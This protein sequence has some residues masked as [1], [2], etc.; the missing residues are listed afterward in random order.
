M[1]WEYDD[2][3]DYETNESFGDLQIYNLE[4]GWFQDP[5]R[6]NTEFLFSPDGVTTSAAGSS[7]FT[8]ASNLPQLF[9]S[10]GWTYDSLWRPDQTGDNITLTL[11]QNTSVFTGLPNHPYTS[12]EA[13]TQTLDREFEGA[14]WEGTW[15][16]DQ[17]TLDIQSSSTNLRSFYYVGESGND[18]LTIR[19]DFSVLDGN[20]E[21]ADNSPS[22]VGQEFS[23]GSG[24]DTLIIDANYAD[25]F[26]VNFSE[27]ERDYAAYDLGKIETRFE[28]NGPGSSYF[29]AI[30]VE[31][32]V[33]SDKTFTAYDGTY[34][35]P[36][37][38]PTAKYFN[39]GLVIQE[40]DVQSG[41][42]FGSIY[43]EL[44]K[45][46]DYEPSGDYPGYV[47]TADDFQALEVDYDFG[48]GSYFSLQDGG[49]KVDESGNITIDTNAPIYQELYQGDREEIRVV[50]NVTDDYYRTDEG[51]VT[52][53]VLGAGPQAKDF[54]SGLVI[55]EDIIQSGLNFGTIYSELV[56]T[57]AYEASDDNPGYIFTARDFEA[58]E[59]ILGSDD[60]VSLHEGG[61]TVDENGNITIDTN[62]S[63][64]QKLNDGDQEQAAVLFKVTDNNN[65]SDIGSVYFDVT[66]KDDPTGPASLGLSYELYNSDG[67]ALTQLSVL[68]DDVKDTAKFV[69]NI[70]AESLESDFELESTDLTVRFNPNL[71]NSIEASDITIGGSLPVANAVQIDNTLGTIRIAA[72]SLSELGEG[73]SITDPSSLA[74]ISLDFD[75]E[76][77]KTL[78]KNDD[79]SLK[80]NPLAFGITANSEE[81]IFSTNFD[82]GSGFENR[83]I[84]TLENLGGS[85]SVEGKDVTLYEAKIN[86]AQ[87]G[88]GLVLGT[89]RVI[90]SDASTTNLIRS[91]DTL[92]TSAEWLNIGNIK[93]H[94]LS[95]EGLHN[96][97]A[98]LINAEFS[99]S[100]I[101]S[102][103]FI[104]GV[105]VKEAR[106]STTLTTDIK[107][108][109]AAGN[110]VDLADGIVSVKA[111]AEGSEIFTNQ[112]KGSSNL[113]T[114]QGDLNYD[115][116]VS[117]KDLAY[118]NAGA[119]RQQ[120]VTI[121]NAGDEAV[122]LEGDGI[123]DAS[124]ARDVDADFNG[125]I[126][127][128]D[129]SVLDADWGK[130][131]HTGDHQFQGSADISW[132]QLDSQGESSTWDNTSFKNQNAIE[133]DSGYVGSLEAPG[134][135]GVIGSDGNQDGPNSLD[136]E[137]YQNDSGM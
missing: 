18:T 137:F 19:G 126:D 70:K 68:G 106:E 85:I 8:F 134:T 44:V 28:I 50:F 39:S 98:S 5:F 105:F 24:Y 27:Q 47:F 97:N 77:I 114:F 82:D 133:A 3:Y 43:S 64:Y 118:L 35:G 17:F 62:A 132:N 78:A 104:D 66:G 96:Q 90:G 84:S 15:Y 74:S 76:Q 37:S 125:R 124:V 75:E 119:A 80:I 103:S 32:V 67:N 33:F 1:A 79:G 115:G 127:L 91:G 83:Q 120:Q 4:T 57:K 53:E 117:M 72:A 123:V 81:T 40:G 13:L 56:K 9:N 58:L 130:T 22:Q 16:D 63:V 69:L 108:T 99:K 59:V 30:D 60:P 38:G 51:L 88:D 129:L 109:G 61:I 92:T 2:N 111:D 102:G 29:Q 12:L 7:G 136:G 89:K 34:L 122:D 11:N 48:S 116:R 49:I 36:V 71:F 87:Q 25:N 94:N 121:E 101:N 52:F 31:K 100:S 14:Y 86:L 107:V 73:N 95:Y 21:G 26:T 10:D 55:E 110:V 65:Y 41:L 128:G 113:I 135:Y 93:A 23:G 54:E 42:N 46:K 20:H 6:Q 131:L 112:G 45:A